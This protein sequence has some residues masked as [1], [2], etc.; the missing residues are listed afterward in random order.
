MVGSLN[1]AQKTEKTSAPGLKPI[2]TSD[3]Q[4]SSPG[5]ML[6]TLQAEILDALPTDD[7]DAIASRRDLVLIN[8]LMGNQRWMRRALHQFAIGHDSVLEL[9]AGAGD[10]AGWLG[11]QQHVPPT[12]CGL[13]LA[14]RPTGW[15]SGWNW[16]QQDLLSF[17]GYAE[18][19]VVIA[20]LTLH[21]FDADALAILGEKLRS[22]PRVIL[23]CEP[24]RK[25]FHLWQARLLWILGVNHV[26]RHDAPVSV[27]AGFR[28]NELPQLLGLAGPDWRTTVAETWRG[29][30]RMIAVRNSPP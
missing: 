17:A 12:I 1:G 30:Y 23:A 5:S 4:T 20:N 15:P 6:R 2:P 10:F 16:I 18:F 26:T 24:A 7:A 19:E 28:G 21:H 11:P 29:A 22:G 9:G 8:H 27:C 25:R 3:P 13:D 14:P